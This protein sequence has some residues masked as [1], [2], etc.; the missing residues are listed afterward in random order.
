MSITLSAGDSINL[1]TGEVT[2]TCGTLRTNGDFREQIL[3]DSRTRVARGDL[4]ALWY[5]MRHTTTTSQEG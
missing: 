4:N 1:S 3:R 2:R 5:V